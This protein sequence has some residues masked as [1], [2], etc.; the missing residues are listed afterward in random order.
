MAR[1]GLQAET[2]NSGQALH[3]YMVNWSKLYWYL[4]ATELSSG[5]FF[6]YE[7]MY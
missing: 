2:E 4:P 1:I 7:K 3:Q 6:K 5:M